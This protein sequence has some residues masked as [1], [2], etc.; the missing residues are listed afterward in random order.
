M[1]NSIPPQSL[2]WRCAAHA[3]LAAARHA[4]AGAE[5]ATVQGR[6]GRFHIGPQVGALLPVSAWRAEQMR[7][8]GAP[9]GGTPPAEPLFFCYD[10]PD[11]MNA[12]REAPCVVRA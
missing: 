1:M 3:P 9:Q 2:L 4:A 12:R 8:A 6:S 10:A 5:A 11:Q 7:P